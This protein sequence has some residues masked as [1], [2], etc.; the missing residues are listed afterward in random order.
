VLPSR[1]RNAQG[2]V[3][4]TIENLTI[5]QNIITRKKQQRPPSKKKKRE[6]KPTPEE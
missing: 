1:Q 5:F 4:F 3:C 2:E 6:K